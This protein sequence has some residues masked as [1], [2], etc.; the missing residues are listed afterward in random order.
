MSEP[1]A[2]LREFLRSRRAK[3]TPEEA[4][5][6]P[7]PGARRVPGL[8]REEV[9]QLAGVSVD[10]YV[11]LERGRNLNVSESVLD[12]VARALR[13]NELERSHLFTLAKPRRGR[14]RA[15]PP[16]R[17][18]PGL[19]LVLDSLT[20]VPALV[21]GR[22]MDVLAANR[23]ARALYTDFDALPARSRNMA[24]LIFLDDAMRAVYADWEGAARGIV[25]SLH[26]YAGRN[27]HDPALADLVGELS[28]RD[29]DFRHWWADHDVFER[30]HGVKHLHHPLVGELVLGYEAFTP[31]DDPEQTLGIS[32]VEPGSPSEE[33]LRLLGSWTEPATSDS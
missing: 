8:R 21:L 15:L 23:L 18:R 11:R 5:L 24:R 9:A 2:D 17:V 31:A 27:P 20:E 26:L 7:Y 28:V 32:T 13:L 19:R 30:T 12:A 16:Q 33:R 22:R 10:Y 4:G 6:P 29:Q 1:N 3:V 25:A 14:P